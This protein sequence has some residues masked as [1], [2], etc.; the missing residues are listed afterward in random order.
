MNKHPHSNSLHHTHRYWTL[1]E[2]TPT[3][4]R[5]AVGRFYPKRCLYMQPVK[6]RN[7]SYHVLAGKLKRIWEFNDKIRKLIS[8]QLFSRRVVL[9][10]TDVDTGRCYLWSGHRG[11]STVGWGSKGSSIRIVFASIVILLITF[12]VAAQLVQHVILV[13]LPAPPAVRVLLLPVACV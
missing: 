2:T 12:A 13:E 1:L 5:S 11:R 8:V 4:S 3:P 9:Q 7:T 10:P 6:G